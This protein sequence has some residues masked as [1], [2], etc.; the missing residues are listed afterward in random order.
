LAENSSATFG[1]N[2][3]SRIGKQPIAIPEKVKVDVKGQKVF[4][5]GPKANSTSISQAHGCQN[6]RKEY[7]V[8]RQGDDSEAKACTG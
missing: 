8:S 7:P 1:K 5:E 3:M 6:R 2:F 4:V